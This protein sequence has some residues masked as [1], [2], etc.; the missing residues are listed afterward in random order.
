MLCTTSP[1]LLRNATS[2]SRRDLGSQGEV[3]RFAKGS[4]TRATRTLARVSA[5]ER[6]EPSQNI[7]P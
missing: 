2:P 5:T 6:F 3:S 7:F 4:P 1:S